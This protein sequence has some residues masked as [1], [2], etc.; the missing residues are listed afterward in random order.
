MHWILSPIARR[1]RSLGRAVQ[2]WW[3]IYRIRRLSA[4][5][6]PSAELVTTLR[7]GWGNEAWSADVSYLRAVF[8][9]ASNASGAILECGTCV[10]TLLLALVA[11]KKGIQVHSLEH[12][13]EWRNVVLAT[14]KRFRLRYSL[15]RAS[16]L[17]RLCLV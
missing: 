2:L 8:G 13:P 14:L 4:D 3:A 5:E 7:K 12:S 9:A 15:V 6:Q 17:R 10:S 11:E 1:A 16:S